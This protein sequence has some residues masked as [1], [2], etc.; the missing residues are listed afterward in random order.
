MMEI[1]IGRSRENQIVLDDPSV[2][3]LHATIIVNGNS[4]FVRDNGS[5]NGTFIN[6]RR[7]QQEA[8]QMTDILKVGNVVVPWRNYIGGGMPHGS[9]GYHQP[10]NMQQGGMQQQAPYSAPPLRKKSNTG[11]VLGGVGIALVLITVG[12]IFFIRN[13]SDT[14]RL[15]GEWE[16]DYN[17]ENGMVLIFEKDGDD[18]TYRVRNT[19]NSEKGEW[20][21]REK[22]REITLDPAGNNEWEPNQEFMYTLNKDELT[23]T[24][25]YDDGSLAD[26]DI[27]LTKRK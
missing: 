15:I 11:L 22:S 14:N 1:R 7:I 10:Y 24:L 17:C 5:T 9:A 8:L 16:C 12:V 19:S 25:V 13:S 18:L 26:E 2:S 21:I 20:S 23:L 4:Y 6:G 27:I 3:R